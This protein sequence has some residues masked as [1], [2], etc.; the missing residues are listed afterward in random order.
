MQSL[1][2]TDSLESTLQ[3]RL[4]HRR[5]RGSLRKLACCSERVDFTSNDYLGLARSAELT[6]RIE[7]KLR[8]TNAS[9]PRNGSTGSRLLS[10]NSSWAEALEQKIATF[11]ETESAIL[12]NSGYD[13]NF[14]ALSALLANGDTVF[15]DELC[16]ASMHDGIRLGKAN[17]HPFKHNNP[18]HL[19]Q[20]LARLRAQKMASNGSA[21]S[22]ATW[23]V[24]ESLYS[25]NGDRAPLGELVS[26][27]RRFDAHL[28]VDE[29][30]A[31][32]IF[33]PSGAGIVQRLGLASEVDVRVHTFG[34]ALGC[35]GAVVVGPRAVK[36][37]LINFARPLIYS[38]ALPPHSL[39][40]IEAVYDLLPELDPAR[41]ELQKRVKFFRSVAE[42]HDLKSLLESESPIQAL[43][44]P[45]ADSVC[46]LAGKVQT[47][48]FDVR[49]ILSPT[50]PRGQERI[51]IC[52]HAYNSEE[53]IRGLVL[54]LKDRLEELGQ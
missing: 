28:F 10:G 23:I 14:G 26:V 47:D 51:R 39:A 32:G 15:Y 17:A 35:H 20:R 13:A 5:E 31:T 45:K 22:S 2:R 8:A 52:L 54:A 1:R 27:A 46:E 24:A 43:V 53:E 7:D 30:H 38:T 4:N 49:P 3:N 42:A 16:H 18:P 36:Q 11:H 19:Q 21:A 12:F 9:S 40:A 50:V 37:Y 33:G 44:V 41:A 25:M 34:K 29:A 48:G 6:R